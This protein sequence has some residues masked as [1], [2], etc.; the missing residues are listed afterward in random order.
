VTV[1]TRRKTIPA[2]RSS[3]PS[4]RVSRAPKA[5]S[6][7]YPIAKPLGP[8]AAEARIRG[9][10]SDGRV[11]DGTVEYHERV[12]AIVVAHLYDGNVGEWRKRRR[13]DR[14]LR[15]L[16][17]QLSDCVHRSSLYR[18]LAIYDLLERHTSLPGIRSLGV[19]AL[20]AIARAPLKEQKKL[21]EKA[22]REEWSGSRVERQVRQLPPKSKRGRRRKSGVLR[23]L[24]Q[25]AVAAEAFAVSS[26]ALERLDVETLRQCLELATSVADDA[27]E[28]H[29]R[30]SDALRVK[31]KAAKRSK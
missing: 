4:A 3:R 25:A 31:E 22:T 7:M 28:L 27:D 29:K 10:A 11:A 9:V 14:S 16:A 5:Q 2:G 8:S 18:S 15:E 13:N 30:I 20:T 6:G 24:E 21:L 12:G 17:D 23:G 26:W 1:G 19:R